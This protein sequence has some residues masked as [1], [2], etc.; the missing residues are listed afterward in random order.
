M[1]L[2]YGFELR[3]KGKVSMTNVFEQKSKLQLITWFLE[4]L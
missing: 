2:P 1:I 4:Q 3:K